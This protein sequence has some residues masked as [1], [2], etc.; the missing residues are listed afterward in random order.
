VEAEIGANQLQSFNTEVTEDTE[1]I[2]ETSVYATIGLLD[3]LWLFSVPSVLKAFL[4][5]VWLERR[6]QM[7]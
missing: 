7:I 2:R 5:R 3:L 6:R 4:G 1:K